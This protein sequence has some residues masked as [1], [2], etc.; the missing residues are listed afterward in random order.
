MLINTLGS[1]WEF[2]R[3]WNEIEWNHHMGMEKNEMYLSKGKEWKKME[4]NGIE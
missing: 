3:E 4:C 1:I 2:I